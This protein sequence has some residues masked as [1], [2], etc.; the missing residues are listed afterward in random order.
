MRIR[1][2][3][4]VP[5]RRKTAV[6]T[7]IP[8]SATAPSPRSRWR[9]GTSAARLTAARCISSSAGMDT[10]HVPFYWFVGADDRDHRDCRERRPRRAQRAGSR[11]FTSRLA[12]TSRT[13]SALRV[14]FGRRSATRSLCG[15]T[16]TRR[17]RCSRRSKPCS[18]FEQVGVE[19]VE[20]PIDMHDIAGLADLRSKSR[21][22]SAPTSPPGC[23]GRSRR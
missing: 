1:F 8:T 7:T 4:I 19:F 11:P 9:S 3:S 21:V 16:R 6:G 20:Q 23:R 5:S 12:S 10:E 2:G 17:G 15:S 14:R 18:R 22:G 13:T